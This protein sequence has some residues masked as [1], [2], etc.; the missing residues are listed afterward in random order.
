MWKKIVQLL[1]LGIA[2]RDL[3]RKSERKLNVAR[4]A[5]KF[6]AQSDSIYAIYSSNHIRGNTRFTLMIIRHLSNSR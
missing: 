2:P 5:E 6:A 4:S 1:N 3:T